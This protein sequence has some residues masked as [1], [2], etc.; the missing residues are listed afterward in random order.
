MMADEL[1]VGEVAAN[2]LNVK[3][4]GCLIAAWI[5][6]DGL[7]TWYKIGSSLMV[8]G[9]CEVLRQRYVEEMLEDDEEDEPGV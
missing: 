2:M 5:D 3:K 4:P 9:L 1:T 8:V 6:E 7:A